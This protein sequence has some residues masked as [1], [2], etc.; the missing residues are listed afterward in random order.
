SLQGITRWGSKIERR[1]RGDLIARRNRKGCDFG[2]A[3]AADSC[4]RVLGVD[5][6]T[7]TAFDAI[8]AFAVPNPG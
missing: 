8:T 3:P 5:A 6:C 1:E 7:V 4:E 2:Y